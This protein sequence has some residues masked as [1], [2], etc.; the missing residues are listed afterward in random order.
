MSL[1][2]K[3]MIL[4]KDLVEHIF[5]FLIK[6]YYELIWL[7]DECSRVLFRLTILSIR[8]FASSNMLVYNVISKN[9]SSIKKSYMYWNCYK[10]QRGVFERDNIKDN[11][12]T[13]WQDRR[14]RCIAFSSIWCRVYTNEETPKKNTPKHVYKYNKIIP[15]LS[16]KFRR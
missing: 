4:Y 16:N 14:L 11:F 13:F 2:T 7:S 9:M 8:N 1:R 3:N 5:N 10:D 12:P 6:D 15:K